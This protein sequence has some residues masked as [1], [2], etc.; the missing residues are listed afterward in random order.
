MGR[1]SGSRFEQELAGRRQVLQCAWQ[2]LVE[3][4]AD[5]ERSRRVLSGDRDLPRLP[6]PSVTTG[7][8]RGGGSCFP[9]GAS[10][11]VDVS[12][13][14]ALAREL[15]AAGPVLFEAVEALPVEALSGSVLLPADRIPQTQ[16]ILE[17]GE[18]ARA[19]GRQLGGRLEMIRRGEGAAVTGLTAPNGLTGPMV[20]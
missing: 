18:W 19:Q 6:V 12:G 2:G 13:F 8:G 5:N 10:T 7:V 16:V 17:I 1:G 4:L 15:L 11:G 20:P 3:T 9:P 14:E